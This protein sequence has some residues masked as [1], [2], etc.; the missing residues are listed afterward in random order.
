MCCRGETRGGLEG[1]GGTRREGEGGLR[2]RGERA[3]AAYRQVSFSVNEPLAGVVICMFG[4]DSQ[5]T[6]DWYLRM[7]LYWIAVFAGRFTVTVG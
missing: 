5:V 2:G 3:L 1:G 6:L 4:S 7:Y